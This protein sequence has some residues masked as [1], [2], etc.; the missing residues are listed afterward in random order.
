MMRTTPQR[1]ITL[2]VLALCSIAPLTLPG[3]V[4]DENGPRCKTVAFGGSKHFAKLCAKIKTTVQPRQATSLFSIHFNEG[5]TGM[6][7]KI[8]VWVT[9]HNKEDT[10]TWDSPK[11]G[12][13][14]R[15]H[16]AETFTIEQATSTNGYYAHARGC[17]DLYHLGGKQSQWQQCMESQKVGFHR[18]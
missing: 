16:S 3:A 15:I 7:C 1:A 5:I 18:N 9:M 6:K 8:T 13:D 10:K 4:A 12:E 2:A 14:C 17:V 11:K